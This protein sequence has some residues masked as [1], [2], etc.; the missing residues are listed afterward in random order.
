MVTDISWPLRDRDM[1]DKVRQTEDFMLDTF[2]HRAHNYLD[3]ISPRTDNAWWFVG[4][5]FKNRT[6]CVVF[7]FDE[8]LTISITPK[9]LTAY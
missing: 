7:K 2:E 5:K 4:P 1:F 8:R 6:V 9:E 3:M